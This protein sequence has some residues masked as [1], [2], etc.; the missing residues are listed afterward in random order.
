MKNNNITNN[1]NLTYIENNPDNNLE[2]NF[3]E[4]KN[5]LELFDKIFKNNSPN[6]LDNLIDITYEFKKEF[7]NG[8][9]EYKRSLIS[10]NN[11]D[12]I[13]KLTRQIYW[14]IYEG[15]VTENIQLCYYIIG[16]EDSGKPSNITLDEYQKSLNTISLA[17]DDTQIQ[18]T[19][20]FI[21]NTFNNS[22]ILVI[23]L[24][25]EKENKIE[26]F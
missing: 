5:I 15:L 19:H 21:K 6:N 17:I 7:S 11:N 13:D 24:W 2:N 26:Y 16:L 1:T 20:L 22:I 23:K 9:I 14:R 4:I 10:Y 25:L 3:K 18:S 12:K 8:S